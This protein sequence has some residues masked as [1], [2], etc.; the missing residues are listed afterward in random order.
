M[1]Q[2][3]QI[4]RLRTAVEEALGR[5]I[6]SYN[7]FDMLS[8]RIFARVGEMI[9]RNTL[10]RIWGKINDDTV[11]RTSTLSILARF[12]GY[13]NFEKFCSDTRNGEIESQPVMGRRLSVPDGL[14]TGDRLRLT[15]L[16]DRVCDVEYNGDL[17]F[18]IVY[19]EN[20]RLKPGDTFLCALIVE[21]APL[22]LDQ[23][24]HNG[25][26]PITYVCGKKTG[27]RFERLKDEGS[28]TD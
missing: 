28:E 20:T 10:R 14:S 15:W 9:S 3:E 22:Y 23:L 12:L 27:V 18:R 2:F 11:P 13:A 5:G 17:H 21:N 19:S 6:V 1:T 24:Q 16:P 8:D 26:P 7:D 25:Q 4:G